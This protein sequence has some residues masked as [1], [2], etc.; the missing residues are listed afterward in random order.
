MACPVKYMEDMER[1][2]FNR[3]AGKDLYIQIY[4]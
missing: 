3:G 4:K 1:S 2:G